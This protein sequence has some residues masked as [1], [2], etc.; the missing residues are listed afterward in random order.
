M[1]NKNF[2]SEYYL[3]K[4]SSSVTI[5]EYRL[6]DKEKNIDEIAKLIYDRFYERYIGPFK[7]NSKR[8]GFSMMAVSCLMIETLYSF[9]TGRDNTI[10]CDGDNLFNWFFN[11][12]LCL[13]DFSDK[14]VN[15]YKSIRC[16]ILHQAET[17]HGWK[18]RRRGPL[19]DKENK[20]INA[21]EFLD[22]LHIELKHYVV[23]IKNDSALY[24]NAIKKLNF[25]CDNCEKT[26][27]ESC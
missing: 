20:T 5:G 2:A 14:E 12:S 24:D 16:G 6:Y 25:I 13:K 15:F 23:S 1:N 8:H 26:S 11:D 4:L 17:T 19:L 27:T 9:K 18:I 21:D 3:T 7:K 10:R 22:R